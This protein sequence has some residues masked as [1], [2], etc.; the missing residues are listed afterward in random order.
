MEYNTKQDGVL[1]IY[2]YLR[3]EYY[4]TN[5]Y[6]EKIDNSEG[7]RRR[8]KTKNNIP[9]SFDEKQIA[10]NIDNGTDSLDNYFGAELELVEMEIAS[11][12]RALSFSQ[13]GLSSD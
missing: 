13:V 9:L 7:S 5:D 3:D 1:P 8:F 12:A 11:R 2:C 6:Y 4:K 10:D